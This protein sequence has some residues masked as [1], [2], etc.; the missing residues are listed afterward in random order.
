MIGWWFYE[1]MTNCVWSIFHSFLVSCWSTNSI[2]HDKHFLDIWFTHYFFIFFV[3]ILLVF[4]CVS[5]VPSFCPLVV[6]LCVNYYCFC[7]GTST[8][9]FLQFNQ[10]THFFN[11][12]IIQFPSLSFIPL[13]FSLLFYTTH[14]FPFPSP[15]NNYFLPKF[16]KTNIIKL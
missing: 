6:M 9:H 12:P 2:Q 7:T 13:Y 5:V 11:S 4:V 3:V 15:F 10:S 1:I 8:A 14:H 16:L